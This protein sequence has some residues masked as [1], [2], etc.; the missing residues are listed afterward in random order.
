LAETVAPRIIKGVKASA[1]RETLH[2]N[3][4]PIIQPHTSA[5][6]DSAITATPSE[7]A[8][9]SNYT[10][11]ARIAPRIPDALLASSCHP[12]YFLII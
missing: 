4:K 7:L 12:I 2:E 8:P 6:I 1:T 11:D 3:K 9:L 10:S 5:N